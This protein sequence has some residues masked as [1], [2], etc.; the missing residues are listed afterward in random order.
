MPYEVERKY[1]L[2]DAAAIEERIRRLGGTFSQ[3]VTQSDRYFNHPA[4][5]FGQTDEA[6]RVRRVG[7]MNFVTYKGPRMDAESKTR[8]ELELPISSGAQAAVEFGQ[9]LE[10][11][12]FRF[13]A[14]VRKRRRRATLQWKGRHIEAVIDDV[15][16][17]GLFVELETLC[18]EED[19]DQAQSCLSSLAARLDLAHHERRSYLE[20]LLNAAL[21]RGASK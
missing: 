7:E 16:G 19:L 18:E 15:E 1:S 8:R 3:P 5:D 11:L 20:L 14:E 2:S 21:E 10:A 9:L 4:R 17:L 6:L 13:V 12:A